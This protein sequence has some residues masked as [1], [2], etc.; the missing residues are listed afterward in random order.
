MMD[1]FNG[2]P[3]FADEKTCCGTRAAVDLRVSQTFGVSSQAA[4]QE[5]ADAVTSVDRQDV[6]RGRPGEEMGVR[7]DGRLLE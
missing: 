4:K 7:L 3:P 1:M 5:R 2:V 6:A